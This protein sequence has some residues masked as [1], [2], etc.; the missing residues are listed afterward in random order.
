[1]PRSSLLSRRLALKVPLIYVLIGGGWI[2]FSDSLLGWVTRDP[3]QLQRLQTFKGWFFVFTTALLLYLLIR[4]H[5][6]SL[7]A[8]QA[9]LERVNRALKVLSRFNHGLVKLSSEGD[10]AGELCRT[11]TEIGGYRLAWVGLTEA[12]GSGLMRPHAWHGEDAVTLVAQ[13]TAAPLHASDPA[14]QAMVENR[15]VTLRLHAAASGTD[16]WRQVARSAG[17]CC[18]LALP[19]PLQ[20]AKGVLVIYSASAAA[21]AE[22]EVALLQELA[23]D[24]CYG[25]ESLRTRSRHLKAEQTIRRLAYYD[26]LTALP[27]QNFLQDLLA[28]ALPAAQLARTSLAMLFVDI[29]KFSKINRTL[30]HHMGDRLLRSFAL[31]LQELL[32]KTVTLSRWGSDVFPILMPKVAGDAEAMA[33]AQ[34]VLDGLQQ[35]FLL[36]SREIFLSASIGIALFPAD[37]TD[38]PTLLKNAESALFRAKR[39]GGNSLLLYAP[40]MHRR[41]HE[42]LALEAHLRR[43]LE[44][45]EF[46]LHFQPQIDGSSGQVVGA[47]ALLRWTHPTL[48]SISPGQFIPLAEETGLIVPIGAWVLRQACTRAQSWRRQGRP[49]I[50]LAV[51]LSARQFLQQDLLTLVRSEL[52]ESGFDPTCLDLEITESAIMEDVDGAVKSLLGLKD[53]GVFISIDDFGTG[54]SSLGYLKRFPIDMLKIDRSFVMGLPSDSD[55]AA[56]VQAIVALGQ[57]LKLKVLA[58]GVETM[59]QRSF[60]QTQGCDYFQGFLFSKPLPEAEFLAFWQNHAAANPRPAVARSSS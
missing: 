21:F 28:E 40:T 48:G 10:L 26:R 34:S 30:G 32:P 11:L 58:E 15:P 54:Y 49:P 1:V 14:L 19:L 43:A 23:A 5:L 57:N 8:S 37:A 6:R 25:L 17:A 13:A 27:N 31:R 3:D 55:D 53:L 45:D 46:S 50:R 38:A 4:Q 59:D 2:F 7:A 47:E 60:L 44:R 33:L 39:L 42:R 41:A 20:P 51:N 24:L 36:Q 56:I 16:P 35:P 12:T 29:D 9:G 18:I 22:E 52:A